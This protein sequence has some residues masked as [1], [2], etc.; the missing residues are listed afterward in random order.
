VR[1]GSNFFS[2]FRHTLS[3][4]ENQKNAAK[5]QGLAARFESLEN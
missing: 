2:I 1:C 3:K 4:S 5:A